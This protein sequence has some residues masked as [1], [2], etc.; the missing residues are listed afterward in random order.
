MPPGMNRLSYR[1][2]AALRF[3]P[4]LFLLAVLRVLL[5][6]PALL[7]PELLRAVLLRPELL[8]AVLLRAVLFRARVFRAAV[9]LPPLFRL[10]L[11]LALF[12]LLPAFLLLLF[13]FA[14]V[15][16]RG[17]FA[18][19]SLASERPIAMACLRL[20]TVPPLPPLPLFSVPFFRRFIALRTLFCAAFPYLRPPDFFVAI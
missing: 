15:R 18:P 6:L 3:R 8:R 17:T 4:A 2:L 1:F 12:A 9:F 19:F 11:F 14:P 7:R 10:L 13:F 16:L 5:F 20:F